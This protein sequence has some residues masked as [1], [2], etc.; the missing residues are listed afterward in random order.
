MSLDSELGRIIDDLKLI[1]PE[2]LSPDEPLV[3]RNW[4]N[5]VSSIKDL[6]EAI[7]LIRSLPP[8]VPPIGMAYIRFPGM[9]EPHIRFATT[10][11]EQWK[12]IHELYP[13]CFFRLKGNEKNKKN[14]ASVFK[15]DSEQV[16][17]DSGTGGE[18]GGQ[19]DAM[20]SHYHSYD[21]YCCTRYVV[22]TKG[23]DNWQQ[24]IMYDEKAFRRE[25][26]WN[27]GSRTDETRPKNITIEIYIFIEN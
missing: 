7:G 3:D 19:I 25:S 17:F 14:V 23:A 24:Y 8:A 26:S 13:D 11:K 2:P 21:D 15:K 5:V 10:R 27:T 18:G 6:T 1:T 4:N 12:P 16:S 20:Q 9:P 22:G